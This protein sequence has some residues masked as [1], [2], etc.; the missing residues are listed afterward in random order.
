MNWIFSFVWVVLAIVAMFQGNTV[1]ML[2]LLIL[3]QTSI[4][5]AKI[6]DIRRI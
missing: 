6:D 1:E 5:A 2:L 3:S 4:I